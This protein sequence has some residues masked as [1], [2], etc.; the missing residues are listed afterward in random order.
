M[1]KSRL[2]SADRHCQ[3][4]KYRTGL[5]SGNSMLL[6]FSMFQ[7]KLDNSHIAPLN[8]S[9]TCCTLNVY[10]LRI[11]PKFQDIIAVSFKSLFNFDLAHLRSYLSFLNHEHLDYQPAQRRKAPISVE[12]DDNHNTTFAGSP[13]YSSYLK[14]MVS[15]LILL[16]HFESNIMNLAEGMLLN[17]TILVENRR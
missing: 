16:S 15:V 7:V 13:Q 14:T 8:V 6:A 17:R 1:R 5:N 2:P 9:S 11:S 10:F 4:R 3:M 12:H